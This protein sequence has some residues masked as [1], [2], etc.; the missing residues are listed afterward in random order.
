MFLV[1]ISVVNLVR[2]ME[3]KL[4]FNQNGHQDRLETLAIQ[5][6]VCCIFERKNSLFWMH[7]IFKL[8][9]HMEVTFIRV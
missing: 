8:E 9:D 3:N 2:K 6:F 4:F 1:I 7:K 5:D